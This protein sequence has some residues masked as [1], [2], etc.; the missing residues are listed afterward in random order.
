M[1]L[2]TKLEHLIV[3]RLSIKMRDKYPPDLLL[4]VEGLLYGIL[5]V[6]VYWFRTYQ[7][8]YLER[9]NMEI[10]IYDL[11]LLISKQGDENFGLVDM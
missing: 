3:A 10:S 4:L 9:L 6:G 5:E 7:A 1:Q 11:Y 8:Y 2:K